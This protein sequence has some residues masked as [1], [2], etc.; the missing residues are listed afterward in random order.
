MEEGWK[1]EPNRLLV[2]DYRNGFL[3]LD[4]LPESCVRTT[5]VMDLWECKIDEE[6]QILA[7]INDFVTGFTRGNRELLLQALH[8]RFVSTGFFKGELQWDSAEAFA[9]FCEEAALDPESPVPEWQ[10]ETLVVSGQTAVAVV[11]DRW[12]CHEFRD[13]LT[14]LKDGERWQIVFKTFHSFG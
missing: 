2:R 8:P 1:N 11:R 14:F 13:S 10:I 4:C 9:A 5:P 12:G 6:S 3:R 7:V